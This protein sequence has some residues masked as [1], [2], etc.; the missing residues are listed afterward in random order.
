MGLSSEFV[1]VKCQHGICGKVY[2]V[3]SYCK[4]GVKYNKNSEGN[5]FLLMGMN[6]YVV[7]LLGFTRSNHRD[8]QKN[9]WD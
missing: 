6:N 1:D 3:I 2:G 5:F 7:F 9:N 4:Y 8:G